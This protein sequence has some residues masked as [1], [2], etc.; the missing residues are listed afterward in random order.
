M[1]I[2]ITIDPPHQLR[3]FEALKVAKVDIMLSDHIHC[4]RPVFQIN[5]IRFFKCA[6]IVL[7]TM[8]NGKMVTHNWVFIAFMLQKTQ[9][10]NHLSH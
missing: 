6:G 3:I 8:T 4:R 5:S 10:L 9:L 2:I 1:N 7:N